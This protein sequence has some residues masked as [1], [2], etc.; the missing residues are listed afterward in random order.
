MI[1]IYRSIISVALATITFLS[2]GVTA[3]NTKA[4]ADAAAQTS[5]V[6]QSATTAAPTL[7]ASALAATTLQAPAA[8][9][10]AA[11][12][13]T[14]AP[15]TTPQEVWAAAKQPTLT[16]V[17]VVLGLILAIYF[18]RRHLKNNQAKQEAAER[19]SL[20]RS[21]DDYYGEEMHN[22]RSTDRQ[23]DSRYDSDYRSDFNSTTGGGNSKNPA[24]L[25]LPNAPGKNTFADVAGQPEAISR[26]REVCE[27]LKEPEVYNRHDAQLPRG[28]LLV[29][30]PG[31]GKTLLARALAGE[32]DASMFITT[33]SSFVEMYVGVGA[34]RVRTLFEDARKQRQRTQK[35]VL[36]FIDEIDA[37]GG[38]RGNGTS[39]NSER[40]QTL[41]QLLTE[42]DG[43]KEN[44]GIIVLAATNRS[45]ML[46]AALK[47]KGRFDLEVFVDLPDVSGREAI[48]KVHSRK[49][50]LAAAV[51]FA[52]IA[53]R[54]FGFSGADIEAA[55]NEAAVIAARKQSSLD[56]VAKAEAAAKAEADAKAAGN[57]QVLI[58]PPASNGGSNAS[59]TAKPTA[60]GRG[61]H[62][63][64]YRGQ[65]DYKYQAP[66]PTVAV[67]IKAPGAVTLITTEM[68][69]EA[70]SIV[71]AGEA[72]KD[73]LQAM[74]LEDKQQ[75]AFHE[76]GHAVVTLVLK[77]DP[78]TKITI[79]P[80]GRAL[81][82][83]QTHT[84][85]DR[86]NMTK[87]QMLKRITSA[88]AGRIAQEIF[89]NT[90]DTGASSDFQQANNMA[91]LMVTQFG[92]S[93]LGRIYLADSQTPVAMQVGPKLA[94]AI[95]SEIQA[96]V[97]QCEEQA[98][99]LLTKYESPIRAL[100]SALIE[101]ET[102][103]GPDFVARWEA[104]TVTE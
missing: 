12:Y 52:L 22:R 25:I 18:L 75:T 6:A 62:Q 102:L 96:I 27:W 71:E 28:I 3:T 47:R 92:M 99:E 35:P 26:L 43:F 60:N 84:E 14:N 19:S 94:D 93:K 95:D 58:A 34:S 10:P 82:Y 80:R 55:C 83:V 97:Q 104:L 69:D 23:P 73:R 44:E 33:G 72:R 101:K 59:S 68:L 76:L 85:A 78:I 13:L 45:D 31:T 36:I 100:S 1:T 30:P 66:V 50:K 89:M 54:T 8:S 49:K 61:N 67:E 88:M 56:K 98:R 64:N 70:I 86:W 53:R 24:Q 63:G 39:S 16:M 20:G 29:G 74:T 7:G 57:T 5:A 42:M 41:N 46:D 15:L 87:E 32:A 103:L 48:F 77:G 90:T 40:E 51:D 65:G 11:S 81:G 4:A 91:K 9:G 79:L 37:V 2:L 38:A 21:D 17:L